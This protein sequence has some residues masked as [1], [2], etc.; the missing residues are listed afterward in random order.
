MKSGRT[1]LKISALLLVLLPGTAAAALD[2]AT[3]ERIQAATYEVVVPK[4]ADGDIKYEKPLPMN[5]VPYAVRSDKYYSIGTAFAIA[6]DRFVTASHVLELE[7]TSQYKNIYLRDRKGEVFEIGDILAFSTRRDFAVFSLK[8]KRSDTVFEINDKPAMNEKV[9][10]VGNALGEGVVIRD[11]LY[12][13]NTPEEVS[14]E[15]KWLRFSAAASPGN[16]GGP[17][18]DE[19]G[20]VIGIV[21]RKSNN[22]NLNF[23]LPIAEVTK[24]STKEAELYQNMGYRLD[25]MPFT[26]YGILE[27]KLTLP[28]PYQKLH[29]ECSAI[30][31]AFGDKLM[32]GMLEENRGKIFPEGR[33]SLPMLHRTYSAVFPNIMAMQED[34]N[35]DAFKPKDISSADLPDNGQVQYGALGNSEMVRIHKPDGMNDRDFYY[36]SK[37]FMDLLLKGDPYYRTVASEKVKITSFGKAQTSDTYVDHYGRKWIVYKWAI[38]YANAYIVAFVLPVPGGAVAMLRSDQTWQIGSHIAD[39]KQLCDFAYVTYYGTFA[40][41]KSFLANKPLLPDAFKSIDVRMDYGKSFKFSSG[42]F[43]FGYGPDLMTI[44][45]D[46]DMHLQFAYFLD[47]G[48][49]VWDVA[50]VVMGDNKN[51]STSLQ[52]ARVV[53]PDKKLSAGDKSDWEDIVRERTPYDRNS[54]PNDSVTLIAEVYKHGLK[55]GKLDQSPVLYT[56]SYGEDGNIDQKR[57]ATKLDLGVKS[58][59]VKEY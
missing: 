54:F 46:S 2:K 21:L 38:P 50:T 29:A 35:W 7:Y 26:K 56:V 8:G 34:G 58:L 17:L 11:G 28:K 6:P 22:E 53:R 47:K 27:K 33:G 31:E 51:N 25:N 12:T 20:R 37:V 9:Y 10:S 48:K 49:V 19:S 45:E 55:A 24:A 14:G 43:S 1:W 39:L 30:V 59:S 41:W 23:A 52:V 57:M 3:I 40:E 4:P 42:R 13:S 5:L 15:W 32:N 36:D 16:S 18:L 44:N